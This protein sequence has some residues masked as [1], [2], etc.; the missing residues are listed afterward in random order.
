MDT[1]HIKLIEHAQQHMERYLKQQG[2]EN[3]PLLV[4]SF[5]DANDYLIG[6]LAPI[7]LDR[8]RLY[9][10]NLNFS[11]DAVVAQANPTFDFGETPSKHAVIILL[12]QHE[13]VCLRT[14]IYKC[15]DKGVPIENVS[16]LSPCLSRS[17][18][19][20]A[21]LEFGHLPQLLDKALFTDSEAAAW[22]ANNLPE[23]EIELIPR[24]LM[25]LADHNHR[26]GRR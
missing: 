17:V 26:P 20:D 15:L 3:F 13:K 5:R 22:R 19:Q 7:P 12:R 1:R 9:S 8:L 14:L 11:E 4:C 6:C 18:Y 2:S 24:T 10:A 25:T 23:D 16:I 21:C